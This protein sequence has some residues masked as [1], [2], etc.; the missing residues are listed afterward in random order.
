MTQGNPGKCRKITGQIG[1]QPQGKPFKTFGCFREAFWRAVA[2]G[3]RLAAGFSKANSTRMAAGRAPFATNQ[4]SA[5][6]N[7]K[8]VPHHVTPV[9]HGGGVRDPDDLIVVTHRYHA[10]VLDPGCHQ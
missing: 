5:G 6:E 3:P 8:Y 10:E 1:R 2:H 7:N 9:Q 4:R